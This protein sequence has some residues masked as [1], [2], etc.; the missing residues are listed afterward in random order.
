MSEENSEPVG[1]GQPPVSTR[2]LKGKSGNP[3]GAA[4]GQQT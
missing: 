2:F 3:R 1:R 4:Q